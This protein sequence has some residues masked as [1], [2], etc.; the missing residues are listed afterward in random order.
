[1]DRGGKHID[2]TISVAIE[3]LIRKNI[4]NTEEAIRELTREYILRQIAA[5]NGSGKT[6]DIEGRFYY[7]GMK[8]VIPGGAYG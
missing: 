8:L 1:M 4:F 5:L 2:A 3:P 7:F 6:V